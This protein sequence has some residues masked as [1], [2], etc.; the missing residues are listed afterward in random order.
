MIGK[1]EF[2]L[3]DAFFRVILFRTF[4]KV[5]TWELLEANF[6]QLTAAHFDVEG[7]DALLEATIKSGTA[8]YGAAYIMPA[9]SFGFTRNHSNHLRLIAIMLSLRVY[10]KIKDIKHMKD[11]HGYIMLFPSMGEFTALQ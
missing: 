11:A 5:E 3:R 8:V 10:D 2:D 7:Y 9:P 1:G 4:N 6:G